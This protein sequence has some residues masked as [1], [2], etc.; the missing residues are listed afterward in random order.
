MK[1]WENEDQLINLTC[2]NKLAIF[3]FKKR[4]KILEV[5]LD[6]EEITNF[7]NEQFERKELQNSINNYLTD[8]YSLNKIEDQ[9]INLTCENKLAI[10]K[11]KKAD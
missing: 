1:G 6:I 7:L 2:E 3:K 9:L 4:I 5:L 8:S 10:F 11:F